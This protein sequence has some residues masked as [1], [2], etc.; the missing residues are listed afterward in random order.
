MFLLL[1]PAEFEAL[2]DWSIAGCKRLQDN[3]ECYTEPSYCRSLTLIHNLYF[4]CY[5]M[6]PQC[7]AA[8]CSFLYRRSR[9]ASVLPS[10]LDHLKNLFRHH[11]AVVLCHP[12]ICLFIHLISQ[13]WTMCT[14]LVL[15][16]NVGKFLYCAFCHVCEFTVVNLLV[17]L[18]FKFVN[19]R[20]FIQ[21][22]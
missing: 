6:C 14:T 4:W 16:N 10:W 20:Y 13:L 8:C 2:I 19:F 15:V 5:L 3:R 7:T 1:K 12:Q 18:Q 11:L 22:Y 17:K 21:F 9:S